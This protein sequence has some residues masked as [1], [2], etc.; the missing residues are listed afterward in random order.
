MGTILQVARSVTSGLTLRN[1]LIYLVS[2]GIPFSLD[3]ADSIAE[4]FDLTPRCPESAVSSSVL[5]YQWVVTLGPRKPRAHFVRL[6]LIDAHTEPQDITSET[7]PCAQRDFMAS[8]LTTV[9]LG[10]PAVIVIDKF[11]PPD[12]CTPDQSAKLM[13]A[14]DEVSGRLPLVLLRYKQSEAQLQAIDPE[15]LRVLHKKRA[16]VSYKTLAFG[17]DVKYGLKTLNLDE[18]KIPLE[19]P[20]FPADLFERLNA[21]ELVKITPER[22]DT[23]AVAAARLYDPGAL[24]QGTIRSLIH[25]NVHPYTSFLRM[26][27]IPTYS[28]IDLIC[29][30]DHAR[31]VDWRTQCATPNPQSASL[32]ELRNRVVV[33][34][35]NASSDIHAT[36]IGRIPG[37]VL[38]ANYIESLLDDRYLKP[39]NVF[40]EVAISISWFAVVEYFFALYEK[41]PVRALILSSASLVVLWLLTY[42]IA[43]LQMGYYIVLW[44]PSALA[45]IGRFGSLKLD[46]YRRKKPNVPGE[47]PQPTNAGASN[48]RVSSL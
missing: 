25:N 5:L 11:Y 8:L 34:G 47:P 28:P 40:L 21:P 32:K 17:G 6:I 27:E 15:K 18:R 24:M 19:W 38:Q 4:F 20:V 22:Q 43:V 42:D 3:H 41:R 12:N 10:D 1:V 13:A 16:V 23:V 30:R 26:S 29:G 9:A 39:A 14:V 46:A 37:V 45:I 2:L 31:D 33:I 7:S 48:L 36:V 35:Q 44:P